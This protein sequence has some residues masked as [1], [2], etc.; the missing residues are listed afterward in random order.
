MRELQQKQKFK[1]RLYSYPSLVLAITFGFFIMHGTL[2]VV[3]KDKESAAALI[4]L[5]EKMT[6]LSDREMELKNSITKLSTDEGI[7]EEIKE[8]FNVSQEGERVAVIVDQNNHSGTS[9]N[10]SKPWYKKIWNAIIH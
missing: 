3:K 8:K 9:T 2:G 6:N 7:D 10:E 1:R 5:Q 4:T